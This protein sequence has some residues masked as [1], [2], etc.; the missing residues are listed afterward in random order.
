MPAYNA[1]LMEGDEILSINGEKVKDWYDIRSLVQSS[2]TDEITITIKRDEKVFTKNITRK[3]YIMDNSKILGITQHLPVKIDET[4]SFSEAVQAGFISTVNSIYFNYYGLYKLLM[5][6][7]S[8]KDNI[9][10]PVMLVSLSK[11]S[12]EKGRDS[13]FTLI[14]VISIVLMM[15]NLL[16]IP[17]LDGGH[18]FFCLLEG[19]FRKPLSIQTQMVL[20]RIGLA[21]LLFMMVFAFF[22]DFNRIFERK[23]SI[24]NQKS[25]PNKIEGELFFHTP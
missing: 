6:P 22:N 8:I 15:M 23:E 16:P 4:Y 25:L 3:E 10:G 18:I 2:E 7:S 21:V 9:G 19:I 5:H 14:A 11:Q 17:I 12:I 13:V 24:S 1:G 20:Q